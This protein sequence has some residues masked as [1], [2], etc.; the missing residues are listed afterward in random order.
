MRLFVAVTLSKSI[1][2]YL[3]SIRVSENLAKINWVS[4]DRIHLTLK[5][6]GDVGAV[7]RIIGRLQN[8]AYEV[9]STGLSGIGV[10]PS[11]NCIRVVW[12]GLEPEADLIR[13]QKQIDENLETLFE[14]EKDYRPHITIGRVK[15]LHNKKK[16]LQD[17]EKIKI[18]NRKLVVDNFKLM[19]STLTSG[20]PAYEVIETF[21]GGGAT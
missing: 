2:E 1:C 21:S 20:G 17:L 6:L 18:E 14:K 8:V 13:L 7:D 16:F 3:S 15:A 5:F 12:I 19:G 4:R 10:F 11:K 9:F